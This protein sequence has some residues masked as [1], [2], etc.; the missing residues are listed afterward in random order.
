MARSL[1]GNHIAAGKPEIDDIKAPTL[2]AFGS[3][4]GGLEVDL[5]DNDVPV[6]CNPARQ[7][8]DVNDI[9]SSPFCQGRAAGCMEGN[10]EC[11][12]S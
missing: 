1:D 6:L 4:R 10:I 11:P 9:L 2:V 7:P 3:G 8:R 12:L 5:T